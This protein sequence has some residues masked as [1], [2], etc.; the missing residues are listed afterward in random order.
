MNL[1]FHVTIAPFLL[2][3]RG[4][5]N[6]S[7]AST[8][9]QLLVHENDHFNNLLMMLVLRCY[10]LD[11]RKGSVKRR[12]MPAHSGNEMFIYREWF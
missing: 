1:T 7:H 4:T 2:E 10:S 3:F 6:L 5:V 11:G 9:P 8:M 12:R